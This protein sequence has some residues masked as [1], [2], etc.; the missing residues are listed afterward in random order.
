[1]SLK[2]KTNQIKVHESCKCA[3]RL[4]PIICNNKQKLNKG[5]C[6]CQ[7]KQSVH[8]KSNKNFV[9]NPSS[10]K[11]EYKRKAAHLLT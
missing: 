2:N 7:C 1:M 9:W 8:K 5:K 6:R 3:C 11:C 10:C 4:D